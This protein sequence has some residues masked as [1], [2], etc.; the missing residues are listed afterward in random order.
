MARRPRS[1]PDVLEEMLQSI[2]A[3]EKRQ[4]RLRS[5]TFWD[6]FGFN[7]RTADRVAHVHGYHPTEP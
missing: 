2:L 7:R 1:I 4:R 6:L 5:K 3:T